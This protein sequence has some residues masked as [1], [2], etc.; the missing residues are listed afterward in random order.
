MLVCSKHKLSSRGS[1][2]SNPEESSKFYIIGNEDLSLS[3]DA[4]GS[5]PSEASPMTTRRKRNIGMLKSFKRPPSETHC[6][7]CNEVHVCV[8]GGGGSLASP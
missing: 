2:H 7:A 3:H 8:C 4:V 5:P 1:K 6:A